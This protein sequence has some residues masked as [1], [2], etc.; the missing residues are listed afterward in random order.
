MSTGYENMLAVWGMVSVKQLTKDLTVEISELNKFVKIVLH[1][2]LKNTFTHFVIN[3]VYWFACCIPRNMACSV[4]KLL[5]NGDYEI[6]TS[7]TSWE[8]YN[9]LYHTLYIR[10]NKPYII[11]VLGLGLVA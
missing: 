6:Y 5:L 4:V 3:T 7:N 2:E 11:K 8:K 10:I 9:W 1:E